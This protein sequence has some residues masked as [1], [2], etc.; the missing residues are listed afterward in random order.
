MKNEEYIF[1]NNSNN[2]NIINNKTKYIN[3]KNDEKESH[4]NPK[5]IK[6]L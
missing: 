1:N 5:S 2:K 4:I 6:Y 3:S